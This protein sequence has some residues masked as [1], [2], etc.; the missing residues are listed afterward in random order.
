AL[1]PLCEELAHFSKGI[2]GGMGISDVSERRRQI[3]EEISC[4]EGRVERKEA[5][6]CFDEICNPPLP[7]DIYSH[8][9]LEFICP[10]EM[11]MD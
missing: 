6:L 10:A 5:L 4:H 11:A 3:E 9:I 8:E 1:K 2:W 7:R